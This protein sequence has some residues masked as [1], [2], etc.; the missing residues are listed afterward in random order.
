MEKDK[1]KPLQVLWLIIFIVSVI[2]LCGIASLIMG[3]V[4]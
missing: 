2:S 1:F 4:Q 3:L